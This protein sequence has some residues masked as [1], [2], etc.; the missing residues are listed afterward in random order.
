VLLHVKDIWEFDISP[1]APFR[2]VK[3]LIK[4]DTVYNGFVADT[5]VPFTGSNV[6]VTVVP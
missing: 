4:I 1:T 2:G 5:A 6:A 3:L